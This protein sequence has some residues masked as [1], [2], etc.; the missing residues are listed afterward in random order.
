MKSTNKVVANAIASSSDIIPNYRNA[1]K[2]ILQ[3]LS[4]KIGDASNAI[5]QEGDVAKSLAIK[6]GNRGDQEKIHRIA[7]E[8]EMGL[9]S[10]DKILTKMYSR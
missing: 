7:R 5:R 3:E 1:V 10:L 2:G 4:Q 8:I 6:H 9:D